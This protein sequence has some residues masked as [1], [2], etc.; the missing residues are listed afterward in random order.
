MIDMCWSVWCRR[1]CVQM[2]S[3]TPIPNN[4]VVQPPERDFFQEASVYNFIQ[5]RL[6]NH[7]IIVEEN[8]KKFEWLDKERVWNKQTSVLFLVVLINIVTK[9]NL[10]W[11][12]KVI[13]DLMV[14]N[15]SLKFSSETL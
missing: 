7:L 8:I 4:P 13:R 5:L 6:V 2:V 12:V 11:S 14:S 1:V 9:S 3:Q 10:S 15:L